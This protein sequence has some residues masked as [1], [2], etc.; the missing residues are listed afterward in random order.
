M[1]RSYKI[2]L[3]DILE[4][5]TRINEWTQSLSDKDELVV[6]VKTLH[7]VIRNMEVIGEAV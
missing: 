6:D 7:A 2:F 3:N 4:S 5:I 1:S